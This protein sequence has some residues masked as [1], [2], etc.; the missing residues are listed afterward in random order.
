MMNYQFSARIA[1]VCLLV[2]SLIST[3]CDP[4]N[5]ASL[6]SN[7]TGADSTN[8]STDTSNQVASDT[9]IIGSFN[10]QSF[11]RRKME[12]PDVLPILV[13][14]VR[15]FDILAIQ[16]LRDKD[17]LV[18]PEFLAL[19]NQ[20]GGRF[21]AEVGPRQG[22]YLKKD[23][24][25]YEEQ[26]VYIYDSSR[27]ELI[28]RSYVA[29][30]ASRKMH[31]PPLVARFRSL[32][33]PQSQAFTFTVMNVHVDYDDAWS[34]FKLMETILPSVYKQHPEEDDFILLGDLNGEPNTFNKFNWM[35]NQ[36]AA[37]P[38]HLNTNTAQSQNYDNLV[39]D[40][41]RTS[42]FMNQAGVMSLVQEYQIPIELAKRVSDHLPVWA[43]FSARESVKASLTQSAPVAV[44]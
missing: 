12:K 28:Q 41:A 31:R 15:R 27:V 5:L 11:G 39:F 30:D 21:V 7:T 8:G 25:R 16:E 17:Q 26:M 20:G 33:V 9:V 1:S 19:I 38:N 40:A 42:E 2:I 35:S 13:D 6:D 24:R 23:Q 14:I 37:I 34:E 3:G 10:I 36:F 29:E 4:A 43:V 44:R 18:I 22:Y 32:G